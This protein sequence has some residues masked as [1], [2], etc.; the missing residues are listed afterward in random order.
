MASFN[1]TRILDPEVIRESTKLVPLRAGV[2]IFS[3]LVV[4][5][6]PQMKYFAETERRNGDLFRRNLAERNGKRNETK[7][8]RSINIV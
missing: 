4:P 8:T 7:S 2:G 1:S 3:E 5:P 6:P